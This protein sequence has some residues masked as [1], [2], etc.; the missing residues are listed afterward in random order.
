MCQVLLDGGSYD[1]IGRGRR[2]GHHL[3][4]EMWLV[5]LTA[6]RDMNLIADPGDAALGAMPG[7]RIVG[8]GDKDSI[9]RL[10][11]SSPL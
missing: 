2:C 7:R 9:L 8:R 4:N 5:V 10:R 3:G 11:E 6:L 1:T